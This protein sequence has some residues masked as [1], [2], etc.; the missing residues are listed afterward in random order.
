MKKIVLAIAVVALLGSCK[1]KENEGPCNCGIVQSDNVQNNS[2]VI[3]NEC[4]N[5]NKEFVLSSADWMNAH[6]G[7]RYCITNSG[8]W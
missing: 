7:S 3:K 2:V 8:K 5:N 6:V 4:S 1:K